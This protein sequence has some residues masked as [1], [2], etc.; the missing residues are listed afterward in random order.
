MIVKRKFGFKITPYRYRGKT[1]R[2]VKLL[3]IE[4]K[5]YAKE[6]NKVYRRR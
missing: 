4:L 6:N 2:R 1:A 3:L 5:K